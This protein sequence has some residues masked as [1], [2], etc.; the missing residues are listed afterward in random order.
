MVWLVMVISMVHVV[1]RLVCGNIV[2]VIEKE[3]IFSLYWGN[4]YSQSKI[5]NVLE[6]NKCTIERKMK[7]YDIQTR[8]GNEINKN[9]NEY[10]WNKGLTKETDERINKM[11]INKKGH[12]HSKE[13]KL[14]MSQF[15]QNN[16][17]WNKNKTSNDDD[18]I[19]SGTFH[20]RYNKPL[21]I[22]HKVKLF[23]GLKT[24][25]ENN[26]H[27]MNGKKH[28]DE[29]K[30]KMSIN[31]RHKNCG[32][33]HHNWNNGITRLY[34]NIRE[35]VKRRHWG[36]YV[37]EKDNYTCQICNQIGYE[38]N[39][40]HIKSFSK[41]IEENNIKSL[42]DAYDC[43][44]LFDINNGITLCVDCH[45]WVHNLCVLNPL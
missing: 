6:C 10:S 32:V 42:D 40:H 34:K 5:S 15:R 35:L 8:K 16:G 17:V 3:L 38:L 27:P 29:T 21:D 22:K 44:M 4:Q 7:K 26:G 43:V 24:Y 45:R 41:I 20:P 2:I 37:F 28:S 31:R 18:R 36:D 25:M 12:K 9:N 23:D 11:A 39:A 14:K 1:F 33:N 30:Q 19:L 13:T